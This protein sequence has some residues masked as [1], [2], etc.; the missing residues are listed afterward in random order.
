M[1]PM[2]LVILCSFVVLVCISFIATLL[3]VVPVE[4]ARTEAEA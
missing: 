1:A 2:L 3:P 4:S